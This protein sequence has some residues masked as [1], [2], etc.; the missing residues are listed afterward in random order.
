MC[1][2][3][4]ALAGVGRGPVE[5]GEVDGAAKGAA[6]AAI[7]RV[8][9]TLHDHGVAAGRAAGSGGRRSGHGQGWADG[10]AALGARGPRPHLYRVR[11]PRA[12]PRRAGPRFP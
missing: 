11:P 12:G 1:R 7:G 8:P 4:A 9:A 6:V 10:A 3:A 2:R 5:V